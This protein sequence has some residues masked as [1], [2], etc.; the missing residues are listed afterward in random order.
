MSSRRDDRHRPSA[1]LDDSR[2]VVRR[3]GGLAHDYAGEHAADLQTPGSIIEHPQRLRQFAFFRLSSEEYISDPYE[4]GRIAWGQTLENLAKLAEPEDWVGGDS[5]LAR[6]LPIL[7]SY[8]RYTY[9]RLL[10]EGKICVTE[11][12]EYAAFNTGLMTP[13]AEDVFALFSRNRLEN[14]QPWVFLRWASESDRVIMK[15]YP[16]SPEMVEYARTGAELVYDWR[17]PLKLAYEHILVDNV[18]RFPP[19]L[20]QTTVQARQAL[21]RA[22][23]WALKR[24]RRNYKTVVPQW[25]PRLGSAGV[26]FLMPLDL[27]GDHKV[28]LALLLSA[29]RDGAYRGRTVLTLDMAYTNARLVARPDSEWLIPSATAIPSI[30]DAFEY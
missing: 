28:D 3:I 9:K 29:T 30:D 7:D 2:S 6:P 16:A 11:D 20:R 27:S 4:R 10:L 15:R 12:G 22:V 26:Q 25:H 21:D 8:L 18:E 24:V 14:A 5:D 1:G 19:D 17:R 13:H 23:A